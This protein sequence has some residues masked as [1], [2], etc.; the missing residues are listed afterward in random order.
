MTTI[1]NFNRFE[2]KYLLTLEEVEKFK[3]DLLK[4]VIPDEHGD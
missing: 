2:L 4:Y 3:K 1:H